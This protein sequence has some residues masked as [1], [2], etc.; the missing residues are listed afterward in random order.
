MAK[1]NGCNSHFESSKQAQGKGRKTPGDFARNGL[2]KGGVNKDLGGG[3]KSGVKQGL[4]AG[5]ANMNTKG[6]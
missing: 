5:R 2:S 3:A 6:K 1:M 4:G